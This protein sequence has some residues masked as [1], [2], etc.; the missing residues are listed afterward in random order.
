MT[1]SSS[2]HPYESRP[3]A[4]STGLGWFSVGLGLAEL[5]A[6]RAFCRWLGMGGHERLIQAYGA[7]EV[8]TGIGILTAGDPTPWVRGRVAGDVLD[9]T[10]LA[11]GLHRGN[12]R[13]GNVV[14]AMAAVLGVTAIDLL[15]ARQSTTA[16]LRARRRLYDYSDRSGLPRPPDAMR[17]AAKDAP[18][19]ADMR[20]PPI[21]HYAGR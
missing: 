11:T 12:P 10:T 7:R 13:R 9:L 3:D 5:A 15:R 16:T 8:A 1:R 20:T 21:L 14:A 18:I 19:A 4:V 2:R 17:G 6:P